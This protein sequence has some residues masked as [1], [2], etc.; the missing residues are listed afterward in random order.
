M[1]EFKHIL[2]LIIGDVKMNKNVLAILGSPRPKGVVATML[3]HAVHCAEATGHTVQ[4]VN[5][6]EQT[7]VKSAYSRTIFNYLCRNYARR[8]LLF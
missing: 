3:A 4:T 6:Y 7:P 2:P 1:I 5:L 8:I